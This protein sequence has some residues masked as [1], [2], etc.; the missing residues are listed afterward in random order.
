MSLVDSAPV[1]T[2]DA[3][4][5]TGVAVEVRP[6]VASDEDAV[7]Q[8]FAT[9][10]ERSTYHR[11]F[12]T[13]KTAGEDYVKHLADP[14][15]TLSAIV[16]VDRGAIVAVGS[17]HLV[18]DPATERPLDAVVALFVADEHQGEGMGTLILE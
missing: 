12:S 5:A 7:R 8:L 6:Y 2:Y 14:E 11:F 17:I 4:T 10:G 1:T 18:T 15:R 16:V 9:A 13:A 3:L